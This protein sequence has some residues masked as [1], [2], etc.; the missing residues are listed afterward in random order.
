ML[1]AEAFMLF[2]HR[3]PTGRQCHSQVTQE[4]PGGQLYSSPA[5]TA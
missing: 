1:W 2:L 5:A 3:R 4:S